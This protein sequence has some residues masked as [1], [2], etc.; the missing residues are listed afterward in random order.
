MLLHLSQ[1][2]LLDINQYIF[3]H[4]L[5]ILDELLKNMLFYLESN[6]NLPALQ[7]VHTL[8]LVQV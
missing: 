3:Y 4:Y 2:I 8:K 7:A 5:L 1:S 6:L